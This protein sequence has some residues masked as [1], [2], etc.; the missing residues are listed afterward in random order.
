M[1]RESGEPRLNR[2][3]TP[4]VDLVLGTREHLFHLMSRVRRT[5]NYVSSQLI[6]IAAGRNILDTQTGFRLYTRRLV[7]A[8]GFRESGFEAES[9]ALVRACRR[10]FTIVSVHVRLGNAD[11]RTTSHY[12][13]VADSLR[14][15]R[16]VLA[17][18][19]ATG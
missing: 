8:V 10:G 17:S 1:G 12:R 14:I 7:Q 11:G 9:A 2:A 4:G 18:R 19:F 3:W 16:A 6:S 5:S 13:P 15:A